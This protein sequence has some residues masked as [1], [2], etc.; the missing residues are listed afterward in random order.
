VC[1]QE[2]LT[3]AALLRLP[4]SMTHKQKTDRVDRVMEALGL[5]K[6]KDTI[7][8]KILPLWQYY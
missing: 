3:Y 1:L 7:I 8:G 5:V 2:T 4:G 6:S